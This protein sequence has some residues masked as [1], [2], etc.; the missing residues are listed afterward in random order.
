M[1][2]KCHQPAAISGYYIRVN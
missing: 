2:C 1:V